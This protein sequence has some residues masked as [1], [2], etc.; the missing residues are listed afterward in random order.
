M[1]THPISYKEISEVSLARE[2]ACWIKDQQQRRQRIQVHVSRSH[3]IH[4]LV[5]HGLLDVD[6]IGWYE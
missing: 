1:K 2:I 5:A 6:K 3:I 4:V